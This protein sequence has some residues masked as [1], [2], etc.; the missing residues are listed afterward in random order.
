M[1]RAND[2]Q[3]SR[4]HKN[5]DES[6]TRWRFDH[7]AAIVCK[8]AVR[9]GDERFIE[10]RV[11]VYRAWVENRLCARIEQRNQCDGLLGATRHNE[12]FEDCPLHSTRSTYTW[13]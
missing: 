6:A 12:F 5:V 1:Y 7:R 10:T 4:R 13:I 8:S 3:T 9:G 2:E 11:L